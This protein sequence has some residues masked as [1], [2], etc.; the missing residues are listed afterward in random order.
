M[1]IFELIKDRIENYYG[2]KIPK[3]G[4]SRQNPGKRYSD[5]WSTQPRVGKVYD[6]EIA[7]LV[8]EH[9][10]WWDRLDTHFIC[11]CALVA[12][13]IAWGYIEVPKDKWYF[14]RGFY[15]RWIEED[16]WKK[17][18]DEYPHKDY[19]GEMNISDVRYY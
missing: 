11:D 9:T 10:H 19:R 2:N 18:H 15:G 7:K 12:Q 17:N 1:K 13:D 5:T 6:R 4:I 16:E 3:D 14:G 8:K